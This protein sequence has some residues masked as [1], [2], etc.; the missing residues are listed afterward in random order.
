MNAPP[1]SGPHTD[2]IPYILPKNAPYFALFTSGTE[3]AIMMK[4]PE[5]IPADP[6]PAIARPMIKAVEFG[7][8]AQIKEPI[9]KI[10]ME[11]R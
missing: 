3:H 4:L 9:S 2:A 7:E 11:T 6:R 1:M 5:N 8:I 10:K